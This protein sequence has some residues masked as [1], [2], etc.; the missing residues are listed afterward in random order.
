MEV[1]FSDIAKH[2]WT[3]VVDFGCLDPHPHQKPKKPEKHK[4]RIQKTQE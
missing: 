4:T 2:R 1:Y 3:L